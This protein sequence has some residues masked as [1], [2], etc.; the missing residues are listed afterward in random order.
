MGWC[1]C[2]CDDTVYTLYCQWKIPADACFTLVWNQKEC[3][4]VC[5]FYCV[6]LSEERFELE[7]LLINYHDVQKSCRDFAG[8]LRDRITDKITLKDT[9]LHWVV[10]ALEEVGEARLL[11][12][13]GEDLP[14]LIC[15]S[16]DQHPSG[17]RGRAS[18][19]E[20]SAPWTMGALP[21]WSTNCKLLGEVVHDNGRCSGRYHFGGGL[22]YRSRRCKILEVCLRWARR[23]PPWTIGIEIAWPCCP[24]LNA[25]FLVHA[26]V[27]VDHAR[28]RN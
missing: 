7:C 26:C 14:G 18:R 25:Q 21:S 5:R 13:T 10:Q 11:E 8:L 4:I 28:G 2:Q 9:L 6:G 22:A 19:F 23:R 27:P 24:R 16:W 17:L 15:D 20:D 3:N 1:K 12:Y